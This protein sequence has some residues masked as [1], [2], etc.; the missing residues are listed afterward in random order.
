[1]TVETWAFPRARLLVY[2]KAPRPGLVKTRLI[3]AL[4]AVGAATLQARLIRHTVAMATATRLC[5]V[6]LW[7]APGPEEPFFAACQRARPLTLRC[8]PAGDLGARMLA[9]ANQALEA[10]D[11][12]LIIGTDCPALTQDYLAAAL[13]ALDEGAEAVVGPAEDGGYVLLGLRRTAPALFADMPWGS[14]RVYA[15]TYARLERLGWRWRRLPVLW[16]VDRPEDL[17]RLDEVG[18]SVACAVY[19]AHDPTPPR[20][21]RSWPPG[22]D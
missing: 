16:D 20:S 15:E 10:A 18:I 17:A 9:G 2:A 5:P 14:D 1:M 6:E 12:T 4:G 22:P 3:P 8:Q 19:A 11:Y 21:A 13:R 7:C